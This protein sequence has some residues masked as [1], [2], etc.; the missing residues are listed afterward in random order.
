MANGKRREINPNQIFESNSTGPYRI[1]RETPGKKSGSTT[2]RY[3]EIEFINTGYKTITNFQSAFTGNVRDPYFRN[4]LGIACLGNIKNKPHSKRDYDIWWHMIN[5]CY[6]PTATDYH[7]YGAKGV[8]VEERWLCFEYF[9]DD[10]PFIPNYN[11]YAVSR[12]GEYGFD[13]DMLSDK[14]GI[15]P[16]CYSRTTCAFVPNE[17][18]ARYVNRDDKTSKYKG[19][20]KTQY[21]TYQASIKLPNQKIFIG[22]FDNEEAAARAYLFF[23]EAAGFNLPLNC[24]NRALEYIPIEVAMSHQS[25]LKKVA[26]IV[27]D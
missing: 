4:I 27:E 16:H 18:N 6:N 2:I 10:L 15:Y 22:T 19:V 9:L 7:N 25:N 26:Y 8:Y 17:V 11:S 5:R 14:Y 13:K 24:P 1:V 20:Y 23:A 21:G 12:P 3:C